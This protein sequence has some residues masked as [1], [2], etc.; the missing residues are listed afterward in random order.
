RNRSPEALLVG[1][2]PEKPRARLNFESGIIVVLKL[3][4][5]REPQ[6]VFNEQNLVLKKSAEQVICAAVGSDGD[7]RRISHFIGRQAISATEDHVIS[8]AE[9]ETLTG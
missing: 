1:R 8:I 4:A 6:P 7:E 5:D 2:C 9:P 3:G